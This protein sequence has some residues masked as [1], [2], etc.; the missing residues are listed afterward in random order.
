MDVVLNFCRVEICLEF[1]SVN[2]NYV[3][4]NNIR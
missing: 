2:N 3:I 1:E 4:D